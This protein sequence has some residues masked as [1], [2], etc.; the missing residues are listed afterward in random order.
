MIPQTLYV[1]DSFLADI[2]EKL[3][4]AGIHAA[5]EH[6]ILPNQNAQLVAEVVKV[7]ALVNPAAP[8]THHVHVCVMHGSKQLAILLLSDAS[9]KTIRRNPITTFGEDRHTIDDKLKTLA[10]FIRLL[11]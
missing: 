9:R 8:N 1:I 5:S 4:I 6:E 2:I 11:Y 7:V 10:P 3:L